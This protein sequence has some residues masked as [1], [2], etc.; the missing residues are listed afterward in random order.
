M[1][2]CSIAFMSLGWF[3]CSRAGHSLRVEDGFFENVVL[4]DFRTRTN[5]T[6][7]MRLQMSVEIA[8]RDETSE[9]RQILAYKRPD[10]FRLQV[11]DPMNV[12]RIVVVANGNLL[13]LF[14]VREYE[15]IEAPLRDD[16]LRRLFRMDIRVSDIRTAIV[17]DPFLD[18]AK[19][20]TSLARHDGRIVVTRPS[21]RKSYVE[22]ITVEEFDGENVAKEWRIRP[23]PGGDAE[24]VTRFADYREVGGVLRPMTVTIERAKDATRLRFRVSEAEMNPSL[25][26]ASFE[27]AFPSNAKV[28]RLQ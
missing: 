25:S 20:P 7:A 4:T 28:D 27:L 18:D 6:D 3:A 22:E 24:Q 15:G 23:E 21:A 14:Y 2:S 19:P 9:V 26:D 11:L 10:K 1:I 17:A 16:V 8:T 5:L 12:T 13:R